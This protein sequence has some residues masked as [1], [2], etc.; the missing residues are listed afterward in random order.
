MTAREL[1]NFLIP[2]LEID[3]D[4]AKA[5]SLMDDLDVHQLPVVERGQFK[6]FIADDMLFDE[7]FSS[8]DSSSLASFQLP[9]SKCTIY[10]D[11][12]FYE[13]A[14]V[15]SEC[16][17]SMVA[18]LDRDNIF[19]GVVMTEDL[20]KAFSQTIAVQ[21]PGSVIVISVRQID[22]S[23]SEITRLVE[24]ENTKITG[25]YLTSEKDDATSLEVTLKFDKKNVSHI[26]ATLERFNYNVIGLYQEESIVSYEK[27][28]LDALMKYLNI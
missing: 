1:I 12:H 14:K 11:Q 20:F 17:F 27:E 15:V 22:Y 2:S 5:S 26:V 16:D 4:I 25:C 13:V 28:R 19:L 21:S 24:A 18:V 6:G 23:L 9:A 8:S 10:A 3:D 7:V